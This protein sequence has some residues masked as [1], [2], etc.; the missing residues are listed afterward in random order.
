MPGYRM[1]CRAVVVSLSVGRY[2]YKTGTNFLR[3]IRRRNGFEINSLKFQ[4]VFNL[5]LGAIDN[6]FNP[7]IRLTLRF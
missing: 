1:E 2:S 3:N 7:I 4:R 6:S 5:S